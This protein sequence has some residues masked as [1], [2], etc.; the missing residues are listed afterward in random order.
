MD[1]LPSRWNRFG[2][3]FS[4]S[5]SPFSRALTNKFFE[6]CCWL[7]QHVRVRDDPALDLVNSL[8]GVANQQGRKVSILGKL[9]QGIDNLLGPAHKVAGCQVGTA[10]CA[11]Q[12]RA[13]GPLVHWPDQSGFWWS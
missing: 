10:Q 4:P 9:I 12:A 7:V 3:V 8:V 6:R 2:R 5:A 11:V 13:A 1:R